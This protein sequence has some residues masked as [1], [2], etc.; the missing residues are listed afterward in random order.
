MPILVSATGQTGLPS[1]Q[2]EVEARRAARLAKQASGITKRSTK[3]ALTKKKKSVTDGMSNNLEKLE[4]GVKRKLIRFVCT[5]DAELPDVPA[6]LRVVLPGPNGHD[7]YI[8]RI[9]DRLK[10]A[11]FCFNPTL[12]IWWDVPQ[13]RQLN[14]VV[15]SPRWSAC[16]ELHRV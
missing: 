11:G 6:G 16:R 8:F 15:G 4:S 2:A 7:N 14:P 9:K 5:P 12:K 1:T 3:K 13:M 10:E